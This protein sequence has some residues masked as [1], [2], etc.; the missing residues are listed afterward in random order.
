MWGRDQSSCCIAALFEAWREMGAALLREVRDT[1]A[2]KERTDW[3]AIMVMF[4]FVCGQLFR[5]ASSSVVSSEPLF[6]SVPFL[7]IRRENN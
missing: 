7:S 3:A 5:Y 1:E 2:V 4:F 6:S